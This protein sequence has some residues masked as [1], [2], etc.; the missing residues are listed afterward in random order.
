VGSKRATFG[1]FRSVAPWLVAIVSACSVYDE[2]LLAKRDSI[3]SQGGV[4]NE[5][6]DSGVGGTTMGG[7]GAVGAGGN[8]AGQG[9]GTSNGGS[10]GGAPGAGGSSGGTTTVEGGAAGSD[11]E[12]GDG[13]GGVGGSDTGG[14]GGAAAGGTSGGAKTSGGAPGAGGAAAGGTSGGAKAMGGSGG[15]T[16]S[17]GTGSGGSSGNCAGKLSGGLCWYLGA[18][19]DSCEATCSSHDSVNAAMTPVIG[20]AAQGGTLAECR[21][22]ANLF[23][24]FPVYEGIQGDGVGLGCHVWGT[25]VWWLSEPDFTEDAA[26]ESARVFCACNR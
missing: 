15:T 5:G 22:I 25:D 26:H 14:T 9:G 16:T 24:S 3:S 1:T 4:A 2:S 13:D 12:G 8:G 11:G 23:N 21:T 7:S 19:G 20:T 10:S 17:G 18:L 6:G